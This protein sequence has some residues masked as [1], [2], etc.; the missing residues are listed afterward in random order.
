MPNSASAFA[1]EAAKEVV[2]LKG[3]GEQAEHL[4]LYGFVCNLKDSLQQKPQ[5]Q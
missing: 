4:F 3:A 1:F 5:A 2:E